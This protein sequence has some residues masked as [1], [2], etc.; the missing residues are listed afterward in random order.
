MRQGRRERSSLPGSIAAHVITLAATIGAITVLQA[1]LTPRW[2]RFLLD[3]GENT[4]FPYP[5]TIQ[6][7]MYCVM[8]IAFAQ[9][10]L[11][12]RTAEHEH[13]LINAALLP[14]NDDQ[15]MLEFSDPRLG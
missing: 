14:A 7:F 15:S 8:A 10:W 2:A 12:W 1:T 6:N 11:R 9:L 3:Y 4:V 13:R 5:Y